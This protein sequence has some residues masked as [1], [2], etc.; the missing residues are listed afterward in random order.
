MPRS[1]VSLR[2]STDM[3]LPIMLL[4]RTFA[5][6]YLPG[7][8]TAPCLFLGAASRTRRL[9][10][11]H[12]WLCMFHG[13]PRASPRRGIHLADASGSWRRSILHERAISARLRRPP[14]LWCT[15]FAES[16]QAPDK[17][18]T[19]ECALQRCASHSLDL[20]CISASCWQLVLV[21]Q[22][23]CCSLSLLLLRQYPPPAQTQRGDH[24]FTGWMVE[25]VRSRQ[26]WCCCSRTWSVGTDGHRRYG[27]TRSI[28]HV[29]QAWGP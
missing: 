19:Y 7:N 8:Y 22:S 29:G 17:V 4:V 3:L 16:M 14:R 5:C 24:M 25:R 20:F 6:D 10:Y 26:Q 28:A 2:S 18:G 1:V 9:L 21:S 12:V 15:H 11:C 23:V 27:S 13:R